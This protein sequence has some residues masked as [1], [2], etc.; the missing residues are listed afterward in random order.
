MR[1]VDPG[2][3]SVTVGTYVFFELGQILRVSGERV[4]ERKVDE[5]PAEFVEERC[6]AGA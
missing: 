6:V 1:R 3:Q 5:S 4:G 2:T